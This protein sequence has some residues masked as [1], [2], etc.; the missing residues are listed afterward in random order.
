MTIPLDGGRDTS[1]HVDPADSQ[2]LPPDRDFDRQWALHTLRR[3]AEA[4]E[5]EWREAGK[6]EEFSALYP[7]IANEARAGALASLA[8][9]RGE[10]A[11]TLRKRVSR[12]RQC[13]RQHVK[14]QLVPTLA[15]SEELDDEMRALLAALS[16]V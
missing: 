11:A 12:M 2:T 1:P 4:L 8:S 7:L 6:A 14:A 10:S 3:A 5:R 15:E 13:F 16:G 9:A